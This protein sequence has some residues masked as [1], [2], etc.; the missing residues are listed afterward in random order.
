MPQIVL[1]A[2]TLAALAY[3]AFRLMQG[4]PDYSLG[5]LIANGF[6]GLNNIL[7]MSIMIRAAFWKPDWE[8][9]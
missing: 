2:I 5:G 6:W 1:V 8:T 7:A 9:E 4:D 3:A